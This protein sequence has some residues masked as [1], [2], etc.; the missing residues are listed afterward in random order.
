MF[1]YSI[2]PF[3]ILIVIPLLIIA[4]QIIPKDKEIIILKAEKKGNITFPHL[5]HSQM[6][7]LDC[8]KCHDRQAKE[9][10]I[11]TCSECHEKRNVGISDRDAFHKFCVNCHRRK[12]NESAPVKCAQCHKDE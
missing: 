9:G 1:K 4:E 7:D 12:R 6:E 11:E 5:A 8:V 10:I 2:L 3:C